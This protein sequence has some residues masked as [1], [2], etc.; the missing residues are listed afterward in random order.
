M[1]TS[2]N[3]YPSLSQIAEQEEELQFA[4]FDNDD[5]WQ[6]GQALVEEAK[7]RNAAV[8]IDITRNGQQLF[9]AALPGT[10][11]DNDTWITR[12]GRVVTRFGHSSLYMGQKS[13]DQGTTFE[14]KYQL[15]RELYAAHGGGFPMTIRGVGIVGVFAVSGLPE[16][17]DH[18]LL[19]SILRQHLK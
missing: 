11:P 18:N 16:V 12:K 17:E 6:V 14:A 3:T 10:A 13:R 15:D 9:H 4:T 2:D 19:T 8:T 5:A 1:A 7:R